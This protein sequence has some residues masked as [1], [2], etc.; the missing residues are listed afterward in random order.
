MPNERDRTIPI[1]FSQAYKLSVAERDLDFFDTN[2]EFDTRLFIDPFL[3]RKSPIEEERA[4]F[5]RFGDFFRFAYDKSLLIETDQNEYSNL[6]E[7]LNFHE[8]KEIGLG[9]TEDSHQGS[10]PGPTFADIL[11]KFFIDSTAKRLIK[12]EGLFPNGQFNPVTLQIFIDGI[13]PDSLSDITAGVIMDYLI[14]YTQ[15][16][17]KVLGIPLKLLPLQQDGFDFEEME[18]VGG[19]YYQLPENPVRPGKAVILVPKRFLRSSEIGQDHIESKVKGILEHDPELSKRFGTFLHKTV[20][21]ISIEDVRVLFLKEEGVFKKY[22]EILSEERVNSYDFEK[23]LLK[24]FAVKTYSS[25]FANK[26]IDG[27]I[28]DCEGLL[29]KTLE[30]ISIF[31]DHCSVADGWKDMWFYKDG[32]PDSPQREVVFGRI[33]RGMGYAYFHNFP[34][35]AFE[36]EVGTGNGPVDFKVIY[37]DCRIVIE[38]KKLENSSPKG[39]PQLPSYIHGIQRQ[40]PNYSYLSRATHAIYI[41]GQHYTSRNRPQSNHN[42]RV[43]EIRKIVPTIEK[44]MK[45]ARQ[46]FESLHY[47]NIDLSPHESAS[48][49]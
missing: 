38:L 4:L 23:D 45:V 43:E 13:G 44:E 18:W 32:E 37:S 36:A 33:F 31:K 29:E 27:A 26:K 14:S 3:L 25:F 9:Y 10:G 30:F 21:D 34:R 47:I 48:N 11:F 2:L 49:L 22:L 39:D 24:L 7:L 19:G 6:K 40:L 16:Q 1:H 46:N 42:G 17:C 8:P 12:E 35:V 15:N 20:K 28:A 41:T 5:K